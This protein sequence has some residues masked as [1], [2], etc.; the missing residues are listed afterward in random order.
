MTKSQVLDILTGLVCDPDRCLHVLSCFK[1]IIAE[2]VGRA[3][4]TIVEENEKIL[5]SS[6]AISKLQL[7]CPFLIDLTGIVFVKLKVV[8][9]NGDM[10][11]S[12]IELLMKVYG[13]LVL[14]DSR[15]YLMFINW[16]LVIKRFDGGDVYASRCL[17]MAAD[18]ADWSRSMPKKALDEFPNDIYDHILANKKGLTM[19]D[20]QIED[21]VKNM[22]TMIFKAEDIKTKLLPISGILLPI[23][24][25]VAENHL[26]NLDFILT[27]S[28]S[29]SLKALA[30]SLT[31]RMPVMIEGE[32]GTG[33]TALLEYFAKLMGRNE[34]SEIVKLQ[35]GDQTDS[36]VWMI[37]LQ[38]SVLIKIIFLLISRELQGYQVR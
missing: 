3:C 35:L 31:T 12:E 18:L 20:G 2:L 28:L 32:L 36:K 7:K 17:S 21:D 4:S 29:E 26:K 1:P 11:D 22:E 5:H 33:K 24:K 16:N 23:D 25:E 37:P 10:T 27:E 19:Q 34:S 38:T 15:K 14:A 8:S 30:Y 9:S 13:N 6:Y